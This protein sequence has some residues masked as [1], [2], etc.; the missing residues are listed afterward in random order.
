M[1]LLDTS[2]TLILVRELL[3]KNEQTISHFLLFVKEPKQKSA[4]IQCLLAHKKPKKSRIDLSRVA[5]FSSA[6]DLKKNRILSKSEF[7]RRSYE[8]WKSPKLSVVQNLFGKI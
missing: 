4:M 8:N 6:I 7:Y 2:L 5:W 1:L 3:R